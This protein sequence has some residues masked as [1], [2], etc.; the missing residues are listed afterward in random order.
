MEY[1]FKRHLTHKGKHHQAYTQI[2]FSKIIRLRCSGQERGS[3]KHE[4]EYPMA[5]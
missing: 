1:H 4:M 5:D 2:Y 3:R